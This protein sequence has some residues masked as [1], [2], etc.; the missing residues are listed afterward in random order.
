MTMNDPEYCRHA[1]A[2]RLRRFDRGK[3]FLYRLLVA[4]VA[5]AF[6]SL[7]CEVTLRVGGYTPLYFN[8]LNSFHEP[9]PLVGY[10]GKPN[11]VGRFRKPDFDVVIAQDE[12]GFR[13]PEHL[14]PGTESRKTVLAFGDSFTWGWGVG[15]G[16]VFTDV[17]SRLMPDV[18]V[19]NF[20][21]NASGTVQQFALFEAYGKKQLQPGDVV[22]LMFFNNDFEENVTGRLRAEVRNGQ[23]VLAGPAQQLSYRPSDAVEGSSYLINLVF[24]SA[25]RLKAA[26]RQMRAHRRSERL[27]KLGERAPEIAVFRHYL[28]AFRDACLERHAQFMP[29]YI[30][31]QA[32]LGETPEQDDTRLRN[33]QAFRRAF[34]D[35]TRALGLPA[36]DL[37]TPFLAAKH[38]GP[39]G[40]RLTFLHDAHWNDRGHEVAA[41]A[42]ADDLK[43]LE[44][45]TAQETRDKGAGMTIYIDPVSGAIVPPPSGPRTLPAAP[46][47]TAGLAPASE[48]FPQTPGTSP[49]GG[50]KLDLQGR[51]QSAVVA[52]TRTDGTVATDCRTGD[53]NPQP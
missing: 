39:P 29:V 20:G 41:R 28:A 16:R 47:D 21:L 13:R 50:I 30:P 42:I 40:Q 12:N 17:L 24:F 31:E 26:I 32:E 19:L 14:V 4:L 52:H 44:A 27:V 18:R 35:S 51:L 2:G 22:L 10:R 46:A 43:S 8:P 49:A 37:L 38:D 25:D 5:V 11:F 34:F 3:A 9:D 45:P 53:P 15:Q 6:A 23:V 7:L 36:I 33:D 48:G 1:Q